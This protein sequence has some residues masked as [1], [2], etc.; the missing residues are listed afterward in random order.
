MLYFRKAAALSYI[1]ELNTIKPNTILGKQINIIYYK[2]Y[3]LEGLYIIIYQLI[4]LQLYI[5]LGEMDT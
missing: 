2:I 3:A 1:D 5:P 4:S